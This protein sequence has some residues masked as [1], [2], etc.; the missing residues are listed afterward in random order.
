MSYI[1]IEIPDALKTKILDLVKTT[2]NKQGK[3]KKGMNE[4]TKAIERGIAKLVVIAGDISPA[5]IVMHLP[6][7]S[8]EKKVPYVFVNT[9][10]ELGK[11]ANISIPCSALAITNAP[12]EIES[13]LKD[14]IK[15]VAALRK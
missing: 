1:D 14:I 4:T 10:A 3:I 2:V 15:K 8:K 5:E 7:I 12:K 11:A 6:A 13:D 9:R